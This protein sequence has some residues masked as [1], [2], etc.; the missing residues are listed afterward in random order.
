MKK[1]L[2]ALIALI[3]TAASA[4]PTNGGSVYLG[5]R[6]NDITF[7][8]LSSPLAAY[9]ADANYRLGSFRVG[10]VI[11]NNLSLK[12][13]GM[14]QADLIGGYTFFSTLAD[15][16]IGTKYVTKFKTE[17]LDKKN[18]HRPFVLVTKGWFSVRGTAD[19][20]SQT[21]NIEGDFTKTTPLFFGVG[22]LTSIHAGYTDAN[23]AIPRTVKEIKYTNAYYGGSA[24]LVYRIFNAGIYTVHTGLTGKY[25]T[26]WRV[27]TTL[28]F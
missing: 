6:E 14:Y 5:Y 13:S 18:H 20:E 12:D 15:V 27:G 10:T 24:D 19:L 21:T 16:E 25:T 7:G 28:K 26:G 17:P 22:L 11:Q 2:F 1:I 9:V 23:D 8:K 4:A 3:A